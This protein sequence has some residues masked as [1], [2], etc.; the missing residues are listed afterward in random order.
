MKSILQEKK[1]CYICRMIADGAA[2]YEELPSVGLEM[3][4]VIFGRGRREISERLGLKVWLCVEHHRTGKESVHL[5]K[6]VDLQLKR[7]AQM[8]YEA[9]HSRKE[10]LDNFGKSYFYGGNE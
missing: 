10:W 1:E 3:H 2:Y 5:N 6:E 4:H 8:I 7:T 9:K